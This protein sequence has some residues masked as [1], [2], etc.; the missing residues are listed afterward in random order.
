MQKTELEYLISKSSSMVPIFRSQLALK[1]D[2]TCRYPYVI[3]NNKYSEL[4]E[5]Y[6]ISSS[7]ISKWAM[8]LIIYHFEVLM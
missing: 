4:D 1:H 3:Y 5:K 7:T 8:K 6:M 2:V